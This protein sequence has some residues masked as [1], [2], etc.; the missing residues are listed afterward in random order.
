[1]E[2]QTTKYIKII[3]PLVDLACP[4]AGGSEASRLLQVTLINPTTHL[5][6]AARAGRRC[7]VA[8]GGLGG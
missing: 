2:I 6:L 1:M 5:F 8:I 4:V 3:I 7:H